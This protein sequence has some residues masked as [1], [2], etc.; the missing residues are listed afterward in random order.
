M[1]EVLEDGISNLPGSI[2][3]HILSFAD[4]RDAARTCVLSKRWKFI[5]RS[6][7]ILEF[8]CKNSSQANSFGDFVDTTLELHDGSNIQNFILDASVLS[9]ESRIGKWITT[10][11]SH[12]VEDFTLQLTIRYSVLMPPSLFT[13]ESLIKLRLYSGPIICF[14]KYISLPRL[15]RFL[16]FGALFKDECWNDQL[17]SNCPELQFLFL[18]SC[19][20]AATH[21]VCISNPSLQKLIISNPKHQDGF[22]NC[23]FEIQAP[24]LEDLTYKGIVAKDY[25]LSSFPSLVEAHIDFYFDVYNTTWEQAIHYGAVISKFLRALAHVVYLTISDRTLQIITVA[26]DLRNHIPSYPHLNEL[27]LT[28]KVIADEALIVLLEKTPNLKSLKFKRFVPSFP[29]EEEDD[30][31]DASDDVSEDNHNNDAA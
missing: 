28:Q 8:S 19:T 22:Q 26:D 27:C 29:G 16:L 4:T 18:G 12:N 5:W 20:W 1:S 9:N 2:L 10:V 24:S 15:E 14:P 17:F 23:A 3:H 21:N 6:I 13:C 7:P 11:L 30:I 31:G 25:D